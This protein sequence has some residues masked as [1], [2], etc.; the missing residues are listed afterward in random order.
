MDIIDQLFPPAQDTDD[1]LSQYYDGLEPW[2]ILSSVHISSA[3]EME[4]WRATKY[5][6]LPQKI[7]V[8]VK[9]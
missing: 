3:Q 6:T 1:V 4:Y 9:K 5:P 7:I 2:Q 8:E